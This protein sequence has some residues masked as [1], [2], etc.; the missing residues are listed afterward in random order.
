MA[1]VAGGNGGAAGAMAA[2]SARRGGVHSAVGI[3]DGVDVNST[4]HA[5]TVAVDGAGE[6]IGKLRVLSATCSACAGLGRD[7]AASCKAVRRRWS[8]NAL[9][10]GRVRPAGQP[11]GH[12]AR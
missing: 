10:R 3:D 9:R 2:S 11:A 5:V 6:R 1:S 8:R 7:R 4:D 12:A